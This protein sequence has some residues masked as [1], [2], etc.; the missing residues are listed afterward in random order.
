MLQDDFAV[1]PIKGLPGLP[2]EGEE[3]LWQGHP[4]W[5]AL[6]KDSLN[7]YWVFGYFFLLAL[8]R[9]LTL[10]DVSGSGHA[11][12]VAIPFVLLGLATCSILAL[13]AYIQARC[14]VYTITSK[15]VVLRIGAA[16]T[17]TINLPYNK[18][19]NAT[20]GLRGDGTGNISFQLSEPRKFSFF[21]LWPHSRPWKI[22]K[23]QPSFRSI[24]NPKE[25]ASIL[26]EAAKTEVNT[27][28]LT[29]TLDASEVIV[30]AQ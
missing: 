23:P 28:K 15:R 24:D 20:L 1:E 6:S 5:W 22:A 9:F 7:I 4:N 13:I 25:V 19:V 8:W 21:I 2:P 14:T 29:K 30:P 12:A 17:I 27:P 11:F 16:I 3:I 10:Y 18:I 26:S